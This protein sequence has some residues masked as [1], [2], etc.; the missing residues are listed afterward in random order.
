LGIEKL[1]RVVN[2]HTLVG[3]RESELAVTGGIEVLKEH[4]FTAFRKSRFKPMF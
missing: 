1:L 2:T 3:Y 4:G